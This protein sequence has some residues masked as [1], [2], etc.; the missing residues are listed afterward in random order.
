MLLPDQRALLATHCKDH[1][2]AECPNCSKALPFERIAADAIM[3]KRD[4]CP[5]CRTDLT[6]A[7]L[8]HLAQCTVKRVQERETRTRATRQ[9]ARETAP[10]S[11]QLRSAA[12]E[13]GREA[14]D[15]E[16]RNRSERRGESGGGPNGTRSG[17]PI[18][19]A[20][21]ESEHLREA[22]QEMID[23]VQRIGTD[24]IPIGYP[25]LP[26]YPAD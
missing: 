21:R 13:P 5:V 9:E 2:V 7:L 23:N 24:Y 16:R 14:E 17:E 10:W 4:F 18:L 26:T 25:R 11:R 3:G 19:D 8:Q 1:P 15:V 20:L 12:D 6:A 22:G